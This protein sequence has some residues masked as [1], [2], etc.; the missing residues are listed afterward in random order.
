M[1]EAAL[2]GRP[3]TRVNGAGLG[4]ELGNGWRRGFG[5]ISGRSRRGMTTRGASA[6][7]TSG[8]ARREAKSAPLAYEMV[9]GALVRWS[10]EKPDGPHPPTCVLVHGILGSRRNL[11]SFAKKLAEK[12]PSWQFLLVDLRNHGE[13]N[14]FEAKPEAPHTVQNAARDVLSVL[15]HL[16]IY[17]YTLIGHSFGGKV[18]M[19][20]VHQFGRALPRPVQVWVLDTVP[21]DAWCEDVGDHPRDTINFCTTLE[22]PIDSRRSLVES[23]TGAGFTIEGAQW[24][25]TNLKADG[26]GKFNWTFDLDGIAEMYSSYEACD[27]WPMVETQPVGLSLDFVQAERSAFV[28]RPEDIE[29][30]RAT[31]A[32]VHMLR[33]SAHWVHIDNPQGLLE[34]LAPSFENMERRQSSR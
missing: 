32:N 13:S 7:S 25:T 18:A 33:N 29:R 9:Q 16:K 15:N 8:A 1:R 11:Q 28:W 21:G 20:M 34:I 2:F 30:I 24:M 17:P 3:G 12:F 4:C 31:G 22:R 19:S 6:A 26:A 23:L 10:E 5:T 27:L 14:T